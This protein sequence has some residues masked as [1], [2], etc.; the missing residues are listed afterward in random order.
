M[1][2]KMFNWHLYLLLIFLKGT[3][4]LTLQFIT[5]HGV[6]GGGEEVGQERGGQLKIDQNEKHELI[7]IDDN[8]DVRR[9]FCQRMVLE[10]KRQKS[11]TPEQ[12]EKAR[13]QHKEKN[14]D[15]GRNLDAEGRFDNHNLDVGK[16]R[17]QR[18]DV[19]RG[20]DT[21]VELERRQNS[22]TLEQTEKAAI[23]K[24]RAFSSTFICLFQAMTWNGYIFQ[25]N[26]SQ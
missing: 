25:S 11:R 21:H 12:A 3:P 22:R 20:L 24:S 5:G 15:V 19:E 1:N 13:R 8:L 26:C 18:L 2:C 9:E 10:K 23:A 7:Y 4:A 14:L 17:G 16:E 6:H